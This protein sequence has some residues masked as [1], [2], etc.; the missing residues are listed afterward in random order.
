MRQDQKICFKTFHPN[1]SASR[2]AL[3]NSNFNPTYLLYPLQRAGQESK[4]ME[5]IHGNTRN[6]ELPRMKI[7]WD[8]SLIF[9]NIL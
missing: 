4:G 8:T 5:T 7:Q 3:E 2:L 9:T 6:L 1:T